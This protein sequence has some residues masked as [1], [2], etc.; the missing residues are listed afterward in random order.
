MPHKKY[1]GYKPKY[2]YYSV[3]LYQVDGEAGESIVFDF[4]DGKCVLTHLYWG[5]KLDYEY[6]RDGEVEHSCIW[7]KENT[8]KLMLRTGT[9]NGKDLVKAMYERFGDK[10]S[11][12]DFYIRQFCDEKG[13]KYNVQVWY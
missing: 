11:S 13:I 8:K 1:Y 9:H 10:G 3:T 12:A 2:E 4:D 7:D 6:S 5:S